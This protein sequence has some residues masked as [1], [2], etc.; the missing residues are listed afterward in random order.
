MSDDL[1][2]LPVM[3]SAEVTITQKHLDDSL[4]MRNNETK[5]RGTCTSCPAALA[6]QEATGVYNAW[7]TQ[8]QYGFDP[9]AESLRGHVLPAIASDWIKNYDNWYGHTYGFGA[10]DD[11]VLVAAPEV[12]FTFEISWESE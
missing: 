3:K 6:L 9:I 5:W 7:T 4:A 10:Q 2:F 11:T 1:R 8:G 12:P